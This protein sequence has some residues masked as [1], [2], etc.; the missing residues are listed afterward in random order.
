MQKILSILMLTCTDK[1]SPEQVALLQ[2][3]KYSPS[4]FDSTKQEYI[5]LLQFDL[6]QF[7]PNENLSQE[8][9]ASPVEL[10]R[11]EIY[12]QTVVEV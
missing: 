8:E 6:N 1:I 4:D 10:S 2:D 3:F 5:D 11:E 9:Q 7:L 12:M